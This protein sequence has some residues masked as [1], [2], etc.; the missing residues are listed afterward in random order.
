MNDE[1]VPSAPPLTS[2][3]Y[4]AP[5]ILD[6]TIATSDNLP[7]TPPPAYSSMIRIP[8]ASQIRQQQPPETTISYHSSSPE[9]VRPPSATLTNAPE[10]P[11]RKNRSATTLCCFYFGKP[12]RLRPWM[13]LFHVLLW[14]PII[15]FICILTVSLSKDLVEIFL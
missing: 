6:P 15:T 2:T 1:P 3:W 7:Q 12:C 10:L 8:S 14:Q 13:R 11:P 9:L 5:T 4:H